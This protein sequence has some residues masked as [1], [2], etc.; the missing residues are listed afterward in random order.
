M[1][2]RMNV[3]GG[4]DA[5]VEQ[6]VGVLPCAGV[7]VALGRA[8]AKGELRRGRRNGAGAAIGGALRSAQNGGADAAG[9]GDHA[10]GV[11]GDVFDGGECEVDG[12]RGWG[13]LRGFGGFVPLIGVEVGIVDGVAVLRSRGQGSDAEDAGL[14]GAAEAVGVGQ[15][16]GLRRRRGLQLR[17]PEA[18]GDPERC[19]RQHGK[20]DGAAKGEQREREECD[21]REQEQA[22]WARGRWRE[23]GEGFAQCE[24]DCSGEQRGAPEAERLD[25]RG[26]RPEATFALFFGFGSGDT[27][28]FAAT[29]RSETR[30]L[31]AAGDS[32]GGRRS[33]VVA[34]T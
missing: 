10:R 3:G 17:G 9:D 14:D 13:V 7:A 22:G 23:F 25:L 18:G 20:A 12:Q 8:Q 33:L 15:Q 26:A 24:A 30:E 16:G 4:G 31:S 19:N 27:R 29:G 34:S 5:L 6:V 1:R 28:V 2:S 11:G 21:N 32:V